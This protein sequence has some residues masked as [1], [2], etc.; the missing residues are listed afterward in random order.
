MH[1]PAKGSP[2]R[3][4][5]SRMSPTRAHSGLSF[6][7]RRVRAFVGSR[8]VVWEV[9][10]AAMG[11]GQVFLMLGDEGAKMGMPKCWPEVVVSLLRF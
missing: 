9:V 6:A 11:L 3:C 5:T 7:K 4:R 8:R 2:V 10:T 1:T